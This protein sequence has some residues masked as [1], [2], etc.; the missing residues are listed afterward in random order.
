MLYTV[1]DNKILDIANSIREKTGKSE[2]MTL[3]EMPQEIES[4]GGGIQEVS[5]E[6][7][8]YGF[9][10]LF[11]PKPNEEIYYICP[12]FISLDVG[13]YTTSNYRDARRTNVNPNNAI[14]FS[15]EWDGDYGGHIW[16]TLHPEYIQDGVNVAGD[17]WGIPTNLTVDIVIDGHH[18]YGYVMRGGWNDTNIRVQTQYTEGEMVISNKTYCVNKS[19]TSNETQE[20]IY[21]KIIQELLK[22]E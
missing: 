5:F 21:K 12:Y 15:G 9:K 7:T 13:D 1:E 22:Y 8:S 18:L 14:V 17:Y 3:D 4:I 10:A 6:D 2:T 11:R 16:F 19:I 20:L